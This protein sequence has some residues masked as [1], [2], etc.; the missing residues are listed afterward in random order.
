[1]AEAFRTFALDPPYAVRTLR[2]RLLERAQA[3]GNQ[4]TGGYCSDWADY[5]KRI[6]QLEG[7][8]EAIG[9]CEE[10]EKEEKQGA[11]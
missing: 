1:M 7:L 6:G 10:M 3:L 5:K 4:I 11:G 8:T 2:K 9:L